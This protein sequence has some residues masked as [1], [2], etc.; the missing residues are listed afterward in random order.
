MERQI[1]ARYS[2]L[3]GRYDDNTE[4]W[5]LL[6]MTCSSDAPTIPWN[7]Q[8]AWLR[9]AATPETSFIA[10]GGEHVREQIWISSHHTLTYFMSISTLV[11]SLLFPVNFHLFWPSL[12]L[13]VAE[14]IRSL[15]IN[16]M[17]DQTADDI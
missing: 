9:D 2:S 8:Y 17:E 10:F 6:W 11:W 1:V 5:A 7:G 13:L 4:I 15:Q 12:A 3:L 14:V 16:G